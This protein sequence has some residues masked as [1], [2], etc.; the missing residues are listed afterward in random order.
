MHVENCI[1]VQS[2]KFEENTL[3]VVS[4]EK[5]ENQF[6]PTRGCSRSVLRSK[7]IDV[8]LDFVLKFFFFSILA[9]L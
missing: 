9:F 6:G 1:F 7:S 8:F 3:R 2:S 4:G 5:V